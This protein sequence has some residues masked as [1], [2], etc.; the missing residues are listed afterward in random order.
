L[1]YFEAILNKFV[2][3]PAVKRLS[4]IEMDVPNWSSGGCNPQFKVY[5]AHGRPMN[6]DL[7]F[8]FPPTKYYY[9]KQ[10]EKI[11]MELNEEQKQSL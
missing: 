5:L 3:S 2:R 11:I 1:F 6:P 9:Q 4:K 8:A 7:V 10:D